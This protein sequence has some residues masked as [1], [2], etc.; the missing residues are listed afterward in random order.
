MGKFCQSK[1]ASSPSTRCMWGDEKTDAHL[2]VIQNHEVIPVWNLRQCEFSHVNTPLHAIRVLHDYHQPVIKKDYVLSTTVGWQCIA[3]PSYMNQYALAKILS[4]K[5]FRSCICC[6]NPWISEY[7][8]DCFNIFIMFEIRSKFISQCPLK[9]HNEIDTHIMK[10][11][12]AR[13][14][15]DK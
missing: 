11:A 2:N 9:S 5:C 4:S 14:A 8:P 6:R 13:V 3:S 7:V 10:L 12:C 15:A 1:M